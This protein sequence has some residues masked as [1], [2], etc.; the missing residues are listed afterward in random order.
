LD[1]PIHRQHDAGVGFGLI[2]IHPCQSIVA[3][4]SICIGRGTL[5][6]ENYELFSLAAG[7]RISGSDTDLMSEFSVR[8]LW[9]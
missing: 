9:Y 8:Y 1:I 3:W 5:D 6:A 2:L 4:D 7:G